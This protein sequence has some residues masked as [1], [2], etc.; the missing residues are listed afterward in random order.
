MARARCRNTVVETLADGL[1]T[2]TVLDGAGMP[3]TG[4][5]IALATT[6][7]QQVS[8]VDVPDSNCNCDPIYFSVTFD[9]FVLT[10]PNAQPSVSS[11][12]AFA[13]TITS[14]GNSSNRTECTSA[15]STSST[16]GALL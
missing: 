13:A 14:F 11:T 9:R 4:N 15:A 2:A 7:D 1:P 10:A 3:V 6:L 12:R 8:A 5:T 16:A